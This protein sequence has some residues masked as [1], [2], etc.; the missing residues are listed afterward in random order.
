M[1]NGVLDT[2]EL[3]NVISDEEYSRNHKANLKSVFEY[4]YG[5]ELTEIASITETIETNN[6]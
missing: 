1:G 6:L 4:I 5:F 2:L 3:R